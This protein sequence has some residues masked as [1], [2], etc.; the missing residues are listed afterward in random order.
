[1]KCRVAS[2]SPER[3]LTVN[4]FLISYCSPFVILALIIILAPRQFGKRY[5]SRADLA[6]EH[7]NFFSHDY[8][9]S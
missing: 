7:K 1:M 6:E 5:S 3:T 9:P 8:P 4:G 2:P